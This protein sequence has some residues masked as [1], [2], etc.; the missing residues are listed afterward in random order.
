[1]R[2][3]KSAGFVGVERGG[4]ALSMR[5]RRA[6]RIAHFIMRRGAAEAAAQRR[7]R[8]RGRQRLHREFSNA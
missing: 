5:E 3:G 8:K 6:Q 7:C 4:L 2:R 1:M